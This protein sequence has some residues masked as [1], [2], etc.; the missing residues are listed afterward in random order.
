MVG[1]E[2]EKLIFNIEIGNSKAII[3][4]SSRDTG[5]SEGGDK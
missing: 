2:V 3:N 1:D 4:I 5:I